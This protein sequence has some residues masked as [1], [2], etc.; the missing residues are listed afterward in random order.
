MNIKE[1]KCPVC[2]N[3]GYLSK[4]GMIKAI[5]KKIGYLEEHIQKKC[6]EFSMAEIVTLYKFIMAIH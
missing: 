6:G 5:L 2:G 1:G 4:T 3:A